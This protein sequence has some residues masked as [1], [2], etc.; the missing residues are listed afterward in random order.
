MWAV[1]METEA[2]HLRAKQTTYF[3]FLS[4]SPHVTWTGYWL[5]HVHQ[6]WCQ[7]Y[8]LDMMWLSWGICCMHQSW[9]VE[10]WC[11]ISFCEHSVFCVFHSKTKLFCMPLHALHGSALALKS[12]SA[13]CV[14]SSIHCSFVISCVK[15]QS[16][17]YRS[18]LETYPL[19]YSRWLR[20]I[21]EL[22]RGAARDFA[23]P[24]SHTLG[25]TSSQ[26]PKT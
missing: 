21:A 7:L 25:V 1:L 11:S 16:V 4:S 13:E 6:S 17:K 23:S 2:H 22:H 20:R 5:V 10:V 14:P 18:T 8:W 15:A 26:Q 19:S 9:Y 12:L 24:H 3:R